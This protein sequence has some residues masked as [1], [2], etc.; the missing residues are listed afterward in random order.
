[1][2]SMA[3]QAWDTFAPTTT[4]GTASDIKCKTCKSL[5]ETATKVLS[6]DIVAGLLI[7]GLILACRDI[8]GPAFGFKIETCPGIIQQ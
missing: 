6:N 7:D 5:A 3:D 1:M 4:L 2:F 8:M